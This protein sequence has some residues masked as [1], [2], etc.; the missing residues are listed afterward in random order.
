MV[1]YPHHPRHHFSGIQETQGTETLGALINKRPCWTRSPAKETGMG[2]LGL[3]GWKI[4]EAA[5]NKCSG[6]D[7]WKKKT[8]DDEQ[9]W[10]FFCGKWDNIV[11]F[12][13]AKCYYF[14]DSRMSLFCSM[15]FFRTAKWAFNQ[16][17]RQIGWDT[18]WLFNIAMGNGP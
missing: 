16:K 18:L 15:G 2:A 6:Q 1:F 13:I 7:S 17:I 9:W 11:G 5:R 3:A 14:D 12:S 10:C 4:L 8:T